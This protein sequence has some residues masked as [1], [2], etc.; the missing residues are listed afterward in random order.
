MDATKNRRDNMHNRGDSS[1]A[2][3]LD[4]VKCL[5]TQNFIKSR[6]NVFILLNEHSV[7]HR[8]V[9]ENCAEMDACLKKAMDAMDLLSQWYSNASEHQNASRVIDE[10]EQLEQEYS[11]TYE[12]MGRLRKSK[13]KS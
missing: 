13:T 9:Q 12:I 3:E 5:T 10:M 7:D 6:K 11:A 8:I 4:R 2:T 1:D